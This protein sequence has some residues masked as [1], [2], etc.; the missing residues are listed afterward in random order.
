MTHNRSWIERKLYFW[1]LQ[2]VASSILKEK[3]EMVQTK[4][5]NSQI[6]AILILGNKDKWC[7]ERR[8]SLGFQIRMFVY[9]IS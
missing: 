9:N 6:D 5:E 3:G 1:L 2:I 7:R 8:V 4:E